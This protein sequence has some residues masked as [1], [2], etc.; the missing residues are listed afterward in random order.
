MSSR[1]SSNSTPLRRL[2]RSPEGITYANERVTVDAEG[3]QLVELVFASESLGMPAQDGYG[4]PQFDFNERIGQNNRYAIVRK[5]GWG[6]HSSTWLAKD[7]EKD[8][9]FV[10]IKALTGYASKKHDEG[11]VW[12]ADAWRLLSHQPLSPH[13]V[14]LLDEF[15]IAGKGSAGNHRCFV[16]PVYGGDVYKGLLK[17]KG[18]ALSLLLQSAS[19]CTC[20]VDLRT[21]TSAM[22]CIPTSS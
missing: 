21:C 4:W 18:A 16:M 11:I 6:M 1:H 15:T 14:P 3:N 13:C 22:L 10:A 9:S 7:R 5:L 20:C 8:N 19:R 12:E 2:N 17:S